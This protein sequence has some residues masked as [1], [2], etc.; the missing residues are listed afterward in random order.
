MKTLFAAAA[1]TALAAAPAWAM[2]NE[3]N[4]AEAAGD[5]AGLV[6]APVDHQMG[7]FKDFVTGTDRTACVV[8]TTT[9]MDNDA[10][11]KLLTQLRDRLPGEGFKP[12]NQYAADGPTGGIEAYQGHGMLT[13]IEH[14][15]DAEPSMTFYW[16][17]E[18]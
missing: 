18:N 11:N 1:L 9:R 13:V 8:T 7:T 14:D 5:V 6:G 2:S 4:C 10:I 12:A 15:Y 17:P 16:V 3:A